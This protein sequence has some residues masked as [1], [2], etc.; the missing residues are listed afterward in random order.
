MDGITGWPSAPASEWIDFSPLLLLL[1]LLLMVAASS[2]RVRLVIAVVMSTTGVWLTVH[3]DVSS[4]EAKLCACA[5]R[6]E[7]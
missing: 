2:S 5:S 1:L 6:A 3:E 7:C 4:N